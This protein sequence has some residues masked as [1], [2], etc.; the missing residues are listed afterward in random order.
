MRSVLIIDDA[1]FDRTIIRT[2]LTQSGFNVIGEAENGKKGIVKDITWR[3]TII[4]TSQN[5]IVI[6]PFLPYGSQS[7]PKLYLRLGKRTVPNEPSL[8]I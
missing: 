7:I 2:L 4:E 8:C 3:N 6:V 5:N 1:G